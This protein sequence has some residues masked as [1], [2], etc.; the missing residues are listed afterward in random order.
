MFLAEQNA[1]HLFY[2]AGVSHFIN[3]LL[4]V[5][6][7]RSGL[8]I[9]A[10]CPKLYWKDDCLPGTEWLELTRRKLPEN[11]PWFSLEE[12]ESWSPW[13]S[14][15]GEK[16][17][18]IG[19]LWHFLAAWFWILNGVVYV[20]LLFATGEWRRLVPTSW[21]I[22]PDAL[23]VAWVYL[24]FQLPPRGEPFNA[25]QQLS[26]FS[27]VFL[28]GPFMIVTGVAQSPA[29][30]ARFPRLIKLLGSRQGAR[31]LHFL[32]FAALLAF[33]GVHVF[34]AVIEGFAGNVD[35]LIHGS[36]T[37]QR[38]F[39]FTVFGIELALVVVAQ[40]VATRVSLRYQRATQRV[41]ARI[42][43]PLGRAFI[44][45]RRSMQEYSRDRISKY[46]RINGEPPE[47]EEWLAHAASDF[48]SWHLPVTGLVEKPLD[49]TLEDLRGLAQRKQVTL[50]NCIQG[51]T[52][53]GEWGGVPLDAVLAL[54]RPKPEARFVI[55]YSY[56]WMHGHQYYEVLALDLLE[57]G[58]ALL[59][60]EMN[61]EP[62]PRLHGA[63]CRLR[64]ENALG[65]KMVK[66]LRKIEVVDRYEQIGQGQGGHR[67]DN[68]F[69]GQV[70]MI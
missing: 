54:A 59:A 2:W 50:H 64:V 33:T 11:R 10:S 51:W 6:L 31:S 26:Y 29:I 17:L 56:Q 45:T 37:G 44:G 52:A 27:A 68:R 46:F 7:F 41:L 53:I 69:Y 15:P 14:L 49:L 24:H 40:I 60:L 1:E 12:E 38:L 8:E 20:A 62:L 25:L 4:M 58:Q 55:F 21:Q 47:S 34:L 22:I 66:F 63:P 43:D 19:R 36:R 57:R 28:L 70:P 30:E 65:Y 32:G 42:V 61:G 13:L 5:F 9:L 23:H 67:E 39:S 18:G 16:N 3:L 48:K 35:W